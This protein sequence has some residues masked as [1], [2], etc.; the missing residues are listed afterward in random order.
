MKYDNDE[1]NC[2]NFPQKIR[3]YVDSELSGSEKANFIAHAS[4]CILCGKSLSE[5][6]GIVKTLGHLKTVET[7]RD[8]D[9]T[10]KTRLLLERK[11]L[12]NPFYI[13]SLFVRENARYFIAVP[14][15]AFA[16]LAIGFMFYFGVTDSITPGNSVS[17]VDT[18]QTDRSLST[19]E[20]NAD[21][22]VYTYYVLDSI[23]ATDFRSERIRE[24]RRRQD[25]V[26]TAS[27]TLTMVSF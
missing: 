22:I 23:P 16:V 24:N 14:S 18:I 5:M 26:Q 27:N 4:Q 7:S 9:M 8:F 11:R 2:K 10:M 25:R 3:D 19:D 20:P 6:E 15:A 21:E 1:F 17:A 13:F 12:R